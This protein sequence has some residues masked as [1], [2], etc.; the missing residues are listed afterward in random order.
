MM[1]LLWRGSKKRKPVGIFRGRWRLS[2]GSVFAWLYAKVGG[3][4]NQADGQGQAQLGHR[5]LGEARN[6]SQTEGKEGKSD[7]PSHARHDKPVGR[8]LK[9]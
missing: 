3:I 2:P 6:R 8:I 4:S 7:E 5:I 1:F 9:R